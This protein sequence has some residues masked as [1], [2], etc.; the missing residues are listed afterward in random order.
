MLQQAHPAEA[1]EIDRDSL[2]ARPVDP[3][4]MRARAAELAAQAEHHADPAEAAR[5]ASSAAML[6]V[7]LDDLAAARPRFDFALARQPLDTQPAARTITEIR[8]AQWHQ[9]AGELG[10][11]RR[12][13]DALVARCR[14][15]GALQPLLHFALQHL[16]KVLYELGEHDAA[17]AC[18]REAYGLRQ[19][20]ARAA[21]LLAST[22]LAIDTVHRAAVEARRERGEAS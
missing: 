7:L 19:A 1:F 20:L 3:A 8:L 6:W 2:R 21:E 10:T 9:A 14:A 22:E 15:D 4:A 13:L 18:L 11:A 12:H 16:G 5:A 17:L